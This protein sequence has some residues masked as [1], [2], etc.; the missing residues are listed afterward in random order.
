MNITVKLTPS[1]LINAIFILPS[2]DVDIVWQCLQLF[3]EGRVSI[4]MCN[5]SGFDALKQR[6]IIASIFDL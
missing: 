2:T 5:S 4:D 3:G 1:D 6:Q